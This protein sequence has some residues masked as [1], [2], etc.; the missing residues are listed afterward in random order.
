MFSLRMLICYSRHISM[1]R[2]RKFG[3]I[4]CSLW[5]WHAPA[6]TVPLFDGKSLNGWEGD[7]KW[8]RVE[9]GAIIGGSLQRQVPVNMFLATTHD[10]TNFI[11]KTRFKIAGTNGFVN[12]GVQI[13]SQR[14]PNNTEMAGYQCDL[15]SS[16]QFLRLGW[17]A[18]S[19]RGGVGEGRQLERRNPREVALAVG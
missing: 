13:R 12:S 5:A 4:L 2:I 14:V 6:A 7:L 10:Y 3:F 18:A 9:D 17:Q 19:D 16:P 15:G 8:W 1:Q 11:F